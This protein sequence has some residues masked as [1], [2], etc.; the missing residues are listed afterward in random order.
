MWVSN[1]LEG[2]RIPSSAVHSLSA[3]SKTLMGPTELGPVKPGG[4]VMERPHHGALDLS[5]HPHTVTEAA[6]SGT[7][8]HCNT[9]QM[10]CTW[11][12]MHTSSHQ[13]DKWLRQQRIHAD[14]DLSCLASCLYVCLS[15]CLKGLG[16]FHYRREIHSNPSASSANDR[17]SRRTAGLFLQGTLMKRLP[18]PLRNSTSYGAVNENGKGSVESWCQYFLEVI[19][20]IFG[21]NIHP[22]C[23]YPHLTCHVEG[24]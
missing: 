2:Y 6:G 13:E 16:Y 15:V 21:K 4:I 17:R 7:H 22:I 9:I 20:S 3:L 19:L 24:K 14:E 11:L 18:A 8:G 10:C 12:C 23:R 5:S 1:S